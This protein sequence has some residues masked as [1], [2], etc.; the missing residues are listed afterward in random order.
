[1]TVVTRQKR[2]GIILD[3]FDYNLIDQEERP[4]ARRLALWIAYNLQPSRVVDLGAGWGTYVDELRKQ[5]IEAQGYD[6][7]QPQARPD[8]V[9]TK[10][11]RQ[12]NDQGS[13]VLCLEVAEHIPE[14][15][16]LEVVSAV[17][18][19]CKPGGIIIWSAAHPGQGGVGHINCQ[20][21]D[22]WLKLAKD[23]GL[24]ERQDLY[25]NMIAWITQ[26]YHMGWFKMNSQIWGK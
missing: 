13:L 22:Y 2:D 8:L 15:H 7:C 26:G 11:L 18:Q 12:V 23:V 17:A 25:Q 9:I 10:D 4:F 24:H 5:G 6:I 21:K 19:T 1:M 3:E 16:A 14:K 20:H